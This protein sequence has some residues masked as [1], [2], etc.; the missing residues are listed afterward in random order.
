MIVSAVVLL[1]LQGPQALALDDSARVFC[2][3]KDN[4]RPL[5]QAGISIGVLS[6][7]ST[8]DSLRIPKASD[9]SGADAIK[10]WA[11]NRSGDF[12]KTCHALVG[13]AA[14]GQGNSPKKESRFDFLTWLLPVVAGALLTMIAA[15]AQAGRSRKLSGADELRLAAANFRDATNRYVT[16]W[17]ESL[18]GGRPSTADVDQS[19]LNLVS[20]LRKA[21]LRGAWPFV[22]QLV[23]VLEGD[24]YGADLSK[25]WTGTQ[26]D[27]RL[28]A[29]AV[30]SHLTRLE[31]DVEQVAIC[32][33][34]A[35]PL[36][37][38]PSRKNTP[39]SI[40]H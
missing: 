17:V 39:T 2:Q 16:G 40:I 35:V 12:K 1:T 37:M 3:A 26:T 23:S 6:P 24:K 15:E 20:S 22:N 10:S 34:S 18:G 30:R 5:V 25:D 13:A 7:T 31:A 14:L 4:R 38:R 28:K 19:R 21:S 33:A 11:K 27:T 36:C 8:V 32:C 9:F 29:E